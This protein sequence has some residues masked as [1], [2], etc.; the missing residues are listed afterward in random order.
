MKLVALLAISAA[1]ASC[2]LLAKA[3]SSN[4]DY[5][6]TGTLSQQ[7]FTAGNRW[8]CVAV[9]SHVKASIMNGVFSMPYEASQTTLNIT[10]P[11]GSDGTISAFAPSNQGGVA[12]KGAVQGAAITG[13]AK[14]GGCAYDI[15]LQKR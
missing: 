2:P 4:G 7:A 1:V 6:G 8:S 15:Q 10:G 13:T 3:Q 9:K 12:F 14:S 5:V 11:V